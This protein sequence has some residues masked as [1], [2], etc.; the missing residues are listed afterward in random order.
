MEKI[1]LKDKAGINKL[2][3]TFQFDPPELNEDE[4]KLL[5]KYVK[6]TEREAR[7]EIGEQLQ[8]SL[9]KRGLRF[10]GVNRRTNKLNSIPAQPG[11]YKVTLTAGDVTITKPLTVRKDPKY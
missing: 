7:M 11:V 8:K 1:E 9:E 10:T 2:L 6:A 5:D 4:K 3:W